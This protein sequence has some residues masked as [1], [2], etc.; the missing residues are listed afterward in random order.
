MAGMEQIQ[1]LALQQ[2]LSPQMQQSLHILQ[3]PLMELRQLVTAELEANPTL[4]EE[5][6][7]TVAGHGGA[8]I[9]RKRIWRPMERI[10]CAT[11]DFRAVDRGRPGTA[12]AFF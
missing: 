5:P 10:L 2:T 7:E 4:E 9:C 12:S 3:A 8:R 11:G 6:R 1:G